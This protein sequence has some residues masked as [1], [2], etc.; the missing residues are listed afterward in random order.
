[1]DKMIDEGVALLGEL[2]RIP[3]RLSDSFLYDDAVL[4]LELRFYPFNLSIDL[5]FIPYYT[6][7]KS[8]WTGVNVLQA[9]GLAPNNTSNPWLNGDNGTY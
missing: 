3:V 5:L 7:C 1:M 9:Q 2:V 4:I 6:I 8:S